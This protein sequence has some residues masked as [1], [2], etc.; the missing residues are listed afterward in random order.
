MRREE[1]TAVLC[2]QTIV[3]PA[4][5]VLVLVFSD[6]SDKNRTARRE[7]IGYSRG[8]G[9]TATDRVLQETREVF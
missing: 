7:M 8:G 5:T 2:Q 1:I 3:I 4:V 6:G 9:G